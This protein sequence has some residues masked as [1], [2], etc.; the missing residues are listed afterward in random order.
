MKELQYYAS[1]VTLGLNVEG[2]FLYCAEVERQ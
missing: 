2:S 1:A